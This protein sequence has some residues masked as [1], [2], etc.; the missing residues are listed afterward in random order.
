MH[1]IKAL[2]V[3][4]N[5]SSRLL[6]PQMDLLVLPN[7]KPVLRNLKLLRKAPNYLSLTEPTHSIW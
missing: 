6:S 4:R 2:L 3:S 5:W 1:K 7:L